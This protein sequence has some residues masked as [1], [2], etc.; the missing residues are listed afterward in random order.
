MRIL[1]ILVCG[2]LVTGCGI[3]RSSFSPAKKYSPQKLQKDYAVYQQV[4]EEVHPGLYWYTSKDSMDYYF[5]WGREQLKDSLTETD[6][7]KVLA[8]VTAKINCGHTSVRASKFYSRYIDTTRL[9]RIFPLSLKIWDDTAVVAANLDRRDSLLKRGTMINKING[10]PINRIVDTL[11]NYIPTDGY[12]TTHKYQ[13]L[14]NRGY[15]GSLYT[16]LFGYSPNYNIEYTDSTGRIKYTTIKTYRPVSDT[17]GRAAIR[18]IRNVPQPSRK[19]RRAMRQNSVRLLKID[20]ADH[21]AMMDLNSFGRGYGLK[22]FFRRSFK[23]LKKNKI[24]HLIIDVRGNGGGS[25]TNSTFATRYLS[26]HPFKVGDSLYAITKGKKYSRYI[27]ND[28]FNRLFI[29][30]FTRRKADGFYHFRYFER[31]HF[32]PKKR[33]HFDGK[34][35]ILTGGNSFSATTLF[36]SSLIKQDNVTV[37]GEE[38]GGGAYGNSAWLI[39]DVTLPETKVRFRLPLFRLVIDKNYPKTGKGVQPEVEAK[40]TIDAIKR[41]ADYKIEKVMELIKEDK[42]N[43]RPRG[44]IQKTPPSVP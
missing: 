16:S 23:T 17:N 25:V 3:N 10:W 24:G 37:V 41:G 9:S 29:T 15:F 30:F 39:P 19:E 11:F 21:I 35:Y 40:P 20:S 34:V 5:K 7:R 26:D 38:T 18:A 32:K 12:N 14:S 33:N 31:S 2:V 22:G 13:S 36:T 43:Q 1:L 27:K 44:L 28:F 42:K 4:L 6:F 8:Y